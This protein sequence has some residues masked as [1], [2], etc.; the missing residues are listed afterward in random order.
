MEIMVKNYFSLSLVWQ[1]S[2]CLK[3]NWIFFL[4]CFFLFRTGKT[5]TSNRP[6][7]LP[8]PV[9][10]G[11]LQTT[12]VQPIQIEIDRTRPSSYLGTNNLFQFNRI[13]CWYRITYLFFSSRSVDVGKGKNMLLV[14]LTKCLSDSKGR[15]I[16]AAW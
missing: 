10:K 14:L 8:E 1:Y 12:S 16:T 6:A 2:L 7:L 15:V 4:V 5:H 3:V 9:G 11:L 13:I